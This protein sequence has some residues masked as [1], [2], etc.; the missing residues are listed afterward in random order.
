M[1]VICMNDGKRNKN[2]NNTNP[3]VY[4]KNGRSKL[5]WIKTVENDLRKQGY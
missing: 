1:S 2:N 3:E 5:K 4:Q